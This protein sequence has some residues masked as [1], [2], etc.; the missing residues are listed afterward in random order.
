AN[1]AGLKVTYGVLVQS[2][3]PGSPSEKAGMKTGTT[4]I[5]VAGQPIYAGGDLIVEINS[6]RI[7]TMDDLSSYLEIHTSPGQTVNVTV[8]RSGAT[9]TLFVTLGIRP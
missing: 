9:Q 7:R 1:A 4:L 8:I 2:V 3:T 6:G 5:S